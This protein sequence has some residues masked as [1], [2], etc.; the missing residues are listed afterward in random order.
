[1]LKLKYLLIAAIFVSFCPILV[2]GQGCM[3][4][5]SDEGVSVKGFIQPQYNYSFLGKDDDGNSL[6]ENSFTF[7]RARIGFI[8]SIPYD[9]SYYFFIEISPFK[10]PG[11]TP[12]L[13]D[14]FVTYS[15]LAPFAKITLGQYKSPFSLEQNTGC[16]ALH[17]INRSQVVSQLASPQRDL[18]L[19]ISGEIEKL[20][21]K[22]NIALMNGSGLGTEDD[23]KGKDLIGR[24]VISPL[25]FLNIGGSYRIGKTVPTVTTEKDNDIMR[26]AGEIEVKY[27]D[28]LIQGEYIFG[29]DKLHSVSKV[30]IYGGC[31]GII[32]FVTKQ[33]GTYK[34][35]G[36]FV[37]AM[38]MTKWNFQPVVKYETWEPDVDTNDDIENII[39]FGLNYFLNDWTR[40]QINYLY[41]AEETAAAEYY[42]D[43]LM[44]Q[45]QAKF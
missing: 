27:S 24:V 25:E 2:Q 14:A 32:G 43:M 5:S 13:L 35:N 42:N 23:N 11:K 39:T 44:F 36:Y 9:I 7:N 29:K 33:P 22:Y 16:S 34:K 4:A 19:M 41:A 40:I 3:E 12:Y 17:T 15:R 20:F 18:G 1:M 38:Y 28:F 45:I 26:C 21:F 37:Q 31:G 10:S 30:P 6:D 8:G